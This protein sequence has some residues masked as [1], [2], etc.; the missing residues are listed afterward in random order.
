MGNAALKSVMLASSFDTLSLPDQVKKMQGAGATDDQISRWVRRRATGPMIS[1][2][3]GSQGFEDTSAD[4]ARIKEQYHEPNRLQDIGPKLVEFGL[5]AGTAELPGVVG[6]S[7][8][9]L[10]GLS[11]GAKAAKV[12]KV[13]AV[14][15]GGVAADQTLQSLG[16]PAWLSEGILAAGGLAT[17]PGR[18]I[19]QAGLE[20]LRGETAV[21]T[22]ATTAPRVVSEAQRATIEA[23]RAAREAKAAEAVAAARAVPAPVTAPTATPSTQGATALAAE[24]VTQPVAVSQADEITAKILHWKNVNKL[25]GAQMESAL[26]NVYG[27][28]PKDGRKM[29]A[30]VLEGQG[31]LQAERIQVGAQKVG[32]SVGMTK[33]EIRQAAGPVLDEAR[34]EASPILPEQALQSIIDKMRTLPK[35]GGA[36]EAYVAAATSGK[37]KWQIE[38]IRR[39]LEHLGLLLPIGAAAT[40][41]ATTER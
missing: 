37:A 10:K 23:A 40:T 4:V 32:R 12:A 28:S 9:A 1:P 26:R 5:L 27:I 8:K 11:T 14:A 20:A 18:A 24:T 16:V 30:M 29:I 33:E 39:T 25:S 17:K 21:E 34:G 2:G 38:N 6:A 15:G 31:P 36:R 22:A 35:T 41:A 19:L 3:P 7:M 13:A